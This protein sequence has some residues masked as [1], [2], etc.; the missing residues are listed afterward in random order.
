MK[1]RGYNNYRKLI[2]LII[3][4]GCVIVVLIYSLLPIFYL[5]IISI[6]KKNS[7]PMSLLDIHLAN[8]TLKF[9]HNAFFEENLWKPILNSMAV[10]SIV[11]SVVLMLSIPA[12]YSFSRWKSKKASK[13]FISLLVFRMIPGVAVVIPM[14]LIIVR[15]KMLDTI[16]GLALI[17]IPLQLPYAIWLLKGYFDG[18]TEEL[19]ESA[20]VEGA[21]I[22][23]A[24]I[25]IVLPL[26][27][28]GVMVTGTLVF[29][30]GFIDYMFAVTVVRQNAITLPV[31]IA[32]YFSPHAVYYQEMAAA[33]LLGMLPMIVLY[34]ISR[35]S[36]TQGV[37]IGAGLK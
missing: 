4:Y 34:V 26:C 28:P 36:M 3:I 31:K 32:G 16:W 2:K 21:S 1:T 33:T 12:G 8:Y 19:E 23:L 30:S 25:R 24:L 9:W 35:K 27:L 10:A 11:A 7:L 15:L 22:P 37:V 17:L 20:W 14:F 29:L 18:I 13:L 5:F 6:S